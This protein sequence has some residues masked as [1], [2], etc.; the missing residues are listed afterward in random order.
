[1]W[2]QGIE[3]RRNEHTCFCDPDRPYR[4][5]P[6][7]VYTVNSLQGCPEGLL[8][9]LKKTLKIFFQSSAAFR[10][11]YLTKSLVSSSNFE[12]QSHGYNG[13]PT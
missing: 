7:P 4:P 9:S 8:K 3:T 10:C 1:M 5:L 13:R 2:N 11:F 6:E 12:N